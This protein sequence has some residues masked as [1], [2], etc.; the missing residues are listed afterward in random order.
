MLRKYLPILVFMVG[1]CIGGTIPAMA[2]EGPTEGA[3]CTTAG[4]MSRAGGPE[5]T[6]PNGGNWLIC[7]G[8]NW[9]MALNFLRDD[10]SAIQVDYDTGSCT[11]V[12]SGR[13]RYNSGTGAWTYCN[14]SAWTTFGR[15]GLACDVWDQAVGY[16][17]PDGTIFIGFSQDAAAIVPLFATRCDAGQTWS[18]AA[19]TGTRMGLAWGSS[20]VTRSTVNTFNGEAQTTTLAGF[21]PTAHPAAYYCENLGMHG[22]SDWYLPAL[23]EAQQIAFNQASISGFSSAAHIQTST[24]AD[25]NTEG[26]AVNPTTRGA[27]GGTAKTSTGLYTRCIRRD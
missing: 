13:L 6:G 17:C 4:V 23:S 10:K 22:R 14:G 3:A 15:S 21:G 25:L 5:I 19:C 7:N 1:L 9:I 2:Q 12:K 20:G 16:V 24:E 18:G 11:S 8:A 26:I 27:F